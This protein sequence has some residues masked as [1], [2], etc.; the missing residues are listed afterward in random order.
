MAQPETGGVR[1]TEDE[2]DKL[3]TPS[4]AEEITW[5]SPA[6]DGCGA[7]SGNGGFSF[8]GC[9]GCYRRP[10]SEW[11]PPSVARQAD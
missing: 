7:P 5:D 2:G 1:T 4:D 8:Q 3:Y 9:G 6:T 10:T 11:D